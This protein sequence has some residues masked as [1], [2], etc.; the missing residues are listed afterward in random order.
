MKDLEVT[1][2]AK[3]FIN[4]NYIDNEDCP[5]ARAVKRTLRITSSKNC[6][7]GVD[8]E[9]VYVNKKG[10]T[11]DYKNGVFNMDT[12]LKVKEMI[13]KDPKATYTITLKFI[14]K[15]Y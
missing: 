7:V 3:D 6:S 9:C 13:K 15:L 10:V 4:A 1:I 8:C 5:L 2:I 11:Y 14:R 12:Y